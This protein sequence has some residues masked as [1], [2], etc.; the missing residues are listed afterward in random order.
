LADAPAPAESLNLS[1]EGAALPPG[2][3]FFRVLCLAK[4]ELRI[5]RYG[6]TFRYEVPG[7]TPYT[8]VSA[9]SG[10]AGTKLCASAYRATGLQAIR[11]RLGACRPII[12]EAQRLPHQ[13]IGL[14]KQM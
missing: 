14:T 5:G 3:R 11:L 10:S 4:G 6:S 12:K 9:G 7:S 2:R 13:K 1:P 8:I